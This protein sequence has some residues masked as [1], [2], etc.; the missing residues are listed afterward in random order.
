M[1]T[2]LRVG[3]LLL[4]SLALFGSAWHPACRTFLADIFSQATFS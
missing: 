3:V 4:F 1:N 2:V